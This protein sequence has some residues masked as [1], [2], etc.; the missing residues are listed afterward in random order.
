M[1]GWMDEWMDGWISLGMLSMIFL[2]NFFYSFPPVLQTGTLFPA[3]VSYDPIHL[4]RG[5]ASVPLLQGGIVVKSQATRVHLP[6]LLLAYCGSLIK[7]LHLSK[8]WFP[9]LTGLL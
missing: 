2:L 3:S 7:L 4:P 6:A 9:Y 1:N 5:P 8:L